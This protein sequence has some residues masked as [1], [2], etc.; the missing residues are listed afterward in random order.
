MCFTYS[1]TF[2][3]VRSMTLVAYYG[4]S[5]KIWTVYKGTPLSQYLSECFSWSVY[6]KQLE[7]YTIKKAYSNKAWIFQFWGTVRRETLLPTR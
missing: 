5:K 3:A 1:C 6:P 4:L 7:G 2:A